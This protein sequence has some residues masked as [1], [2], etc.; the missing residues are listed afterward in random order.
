MT[1]IAA[2]DVP[3]DDA[4]PGVRA[5]REIVLGH[6][7]VSGPATDRSPR[8]A[9]G[10]RLADDVV[11]P[12]DLPAVPISAMDG[13]AVRVADLASAAGGSDG[14]VTLPVRA[15]LPAARGAVAPLEPATAVR[16]MTGAPVPVGADAVIEVERTDADRHGALPVTVTIALPADLAPG[17]HVRGIGEEVARG[18]VIAR[19]GDRVGPGLVGLATTLGI[20]ALAVHAA[21][22]ATVLVT[23][24]ELVDPA[25]SDGSDPAEPGAV[26][27]SN[28]AMIAA[29]L[30]ERGIEA[31]VVRTGD[32]VE[33]FLV[34]LDDAARTSDLLVTCGGIGEGAYDVVKAAL[35]PRGR[36]TSR[37]AHLALRPGGPQGVGAVG[38]DGRSE[39]VVHL[40]GTPVGALVGAH[41]FLR[42]L[43]DPADA[44]P[45]LA[46]VRDV[47]EQPSRPHR[48]RPRSAGRP[49]TLVLPGLLARTESGALAVDLLDGSRLT[50]YGRADCLVLAERDA[51]AVGAEVPVL[52]L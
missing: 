1:P 9:V 29:L 16:I 50:P 38:S 31:A 8:A 41:L 51:P 26:R 13:F 44:R 25:G 19:A 14:A 45:V 24:D 42:P 33:D 21:P 20:R 43:L 36:G 32:R 47:G 46:V 7:P 52:P 39:P 4:R 49:G 15:D 34:A 22:R 18:C 6:G 40:P 37:F 11:A 35:G 23:G 30:A 48:V 12:E 2:P 28:S 10:S 3:D 17:R 5:W 27:E